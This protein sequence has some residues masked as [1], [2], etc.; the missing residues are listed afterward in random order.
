[1]GRSCFSMLNIKQRKQFIRKL[2]NKLLPAVSVNLHRDAE[3]AK[4]FI[5]DGFSHC[6]GLLV[7]DHRDESAFHEGIRD[8]QD[9]L[10]LA[11][12]SEHRS[13]QVRMDSVIWMFRIWKRLKRRR[14][15]CRLLASLTSEACFS[16]IENV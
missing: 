16:V 12:C 4:P 7:L 2:I 9:V 13:K 3:F 15:I 8:T 10:V 5:E 6:L 14:L 11:S 1:M